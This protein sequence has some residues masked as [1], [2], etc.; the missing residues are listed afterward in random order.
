M[1][2]RFLAHFNSSRWPPSAA[3]IQTFL[4]HE[5]WFSLAHFNKD[6]YPNRASA[7]VKTSGLIRKA[8]REGDPSIDGIQTRTR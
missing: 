6:R 2:I 7:A 5:Q 3:L 8:G 4:S 1:H